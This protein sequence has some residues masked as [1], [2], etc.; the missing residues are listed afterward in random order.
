MATDS[1]ILPEGFASSVP[2]QV[3]PGG[4]DPNWEHDHVVRS[5]LGRLEG[6]KSS[7]TWFTAHIV[8]KYG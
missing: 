2:V 4:Q 5:W 3:R 8:L 6:R 1:V 7:S